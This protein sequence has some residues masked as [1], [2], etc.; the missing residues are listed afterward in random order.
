MPASK[1]WTGILEAWTPEKVCT[2][3]EAGRFLYDERPTSE[4]TGSFR[5]PPD[6]VDLSDA[7]IYGVMRY[8]GLNCGELAKKWP[9][10]FIATGGLVQG[11]LPSH[12]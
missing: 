10:T 11:G 12:L 8:N 4:K 3:E 5:I 7:M 9:A 2:P 6:F 1:C